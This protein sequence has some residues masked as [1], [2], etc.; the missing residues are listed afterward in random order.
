MNQGRY[1]IEEL[2]RLTGFT[3]RT[4]RYYVQEGLVDPPA[5]RGRGGYYSDLHVAQLARIRVLQEQGYRLD[6][7]RGMF[8][9]QV[10]AD[11]AGDVEPAHAA[12]VESQAAAEPG[13]G[14]LPSF[15]PPL[16][17]AASPHTSWTRHVVA[18]GIEL[19]ISAEAGSRL[20]QAVATALVALRSIIEREGGLNG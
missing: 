13:A 19:H 7:I 8:A 6:A 12:T 2:C 1:L 16:P 11:T 10:A 5:G 3:R 20:G 17:P 18:R 14:V 15:A 9:T 4:V